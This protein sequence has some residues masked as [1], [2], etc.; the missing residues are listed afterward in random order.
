[1]AD[2]QGNAVN[3]IKGSAIDRVVIGDA[4]SEQSHKMEFVNSWT[5]KVDNKSYWRR[6][7]EGGYVMYNM[8]SLP[9]KQLALYLKFRV[10]DQNQFAFDVLVDGRYEEAERD[11]SL[12]FRGS[13]NQ[14]IIDVQKS[15]QADAVVLMEGV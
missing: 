13:R 1:M 7:Y 5:G 2:P 9:E 4:D 8:R 10:S 3:G 6:C 11:L 15:L 12:H 14:R